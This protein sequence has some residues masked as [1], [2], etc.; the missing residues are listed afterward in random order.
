MAEK[1]LPYETKITKIISLSKT[2][3]HFVLTYRKDA[4]A[5]FVA[6]QFLPLSHFIPTVCRDKNWKSETAYAQDMEMNIPQK[7]IHFEQFT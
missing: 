2:V 4:D 6:G 3:K 1:N 7:F 5:H